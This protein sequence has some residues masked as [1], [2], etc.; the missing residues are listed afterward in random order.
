MSSMLK[1]S[2]SESFLSSA[3][4]LVCHY[5][6]VRNRLLSWIYLEGIRFNEDYSVAAIFLLVVFL[7]QHVAMTPV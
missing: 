7:T 6:T 3:P 2:S 1:P 5:E 4:F